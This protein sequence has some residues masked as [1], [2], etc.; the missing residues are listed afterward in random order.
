MFQNPKST[1]TLALGWKLLDMREFKNY[2]RN[3][4]VDFGSRNQVSESYDNF[5]EHGWMSEL[6]CTFP[7]FCS[8][9]L[10]SLEVY[11][12]GNLVRLILLMGIG[13]A[14]LLH[15]SPVFL[16]GPFQWYFCAIWP[17]WA[18]YT[19]VSFPLPGS[20]GICD[21]PVSNFLFSVLSFG[22]LSWKWTSFSKK[23]CHV[24]L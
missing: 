11:L 14:S 13:F 19:C 4:S 16:E 2:V 21:D 10:R 24:C 6:Q 23:A 3:A 9:G 8:I 1:Y 7:C 18:G 15:S 5:A 22:K 12:C 20:L 17:S